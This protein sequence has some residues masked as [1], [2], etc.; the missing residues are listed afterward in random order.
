[1]T[2]ICDAIPHDRWLSRAHLY[3]LIKNRGD[4]VIFS[5]H[6]AE[7]VIRALVDARFLVERIEGSRPEYRRA[8]GAIKPPPP[9]VPT[10]TFTPFNT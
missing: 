5:T 3:D 2:R 7:L 4:A 9:P 10:Q 6:N 1:M 8:E